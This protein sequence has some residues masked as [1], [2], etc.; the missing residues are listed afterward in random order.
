MEDCLVTCSSAIFMLLV[1][2][3]LVMTPADRNDDT[4]TPFLPE[5]LS[6][7]KT[8]PPTLVSSSL[9]VGTVVITCTCSTII[10]SVK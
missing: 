10:T 8:R 9:Q 4:R 7:R 2:S 1:D 3:T 5:H 6:C